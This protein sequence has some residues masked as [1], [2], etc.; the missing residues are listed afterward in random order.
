MN[1]PKTVLI[2]GVTGLVG[3]YLLKILLANGYKAYAL[4][5]NKDNKSAGGRGG[6]F[7]VTFIKRRKGSRHA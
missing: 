1:K 5:R 7:Q 4:T 3:S 2:T 6:G